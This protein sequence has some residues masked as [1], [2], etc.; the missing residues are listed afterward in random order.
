MFLLTSFHSFQFP[1]THFSFNSSLNNPFINKFS[2]ISDI[3][4]PRFYNLNIRIIASRQSK[5]PNLTLYLH[6]SIIQNKSIV[7]YLHLQHSLFS[8][9]HYIPISLFPSSFLSNSPQLSNGFANTKYIDNY[10]SNAI[11]LPGF[12]PTENCWI[13]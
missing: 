6:V 1:N 11:T 5:F 2:Q 3:Q 12:L 10:P 4:N 13:N 9:Y 7:G 8:L